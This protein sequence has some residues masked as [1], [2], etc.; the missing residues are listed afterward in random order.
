MTPMFFASAAGAARRGGDLYIQQNR[1]GWLPLPVFYPVLRLC[2]RSVPAVMAVVV[3]LCALRG[4]VGVALRL[5]GQMVGMFLRALGRMLGMAPGLLG[6]VLRPAG[7]L[8]RLPL[9]ACD[10]L[11]RLA[12]QARLELLLMA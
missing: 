2:L 8:R 5:F 4:V 6:R 10:L 3:T 11:L 7:Q 9:L 12:A 1:K